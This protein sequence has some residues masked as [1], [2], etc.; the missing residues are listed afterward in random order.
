M[1]IIEVLLILTGEFSLIHLKVLGSMLYIIVFGIFTSKYA[2][3]Y[4]DKNGKYFGMFGICIATFEFIVFTL[5]LWEVIQIESMPIRKL[6]VSLLVVCVA[7]YHT[8][9]ILLIKLKNAISTKFSIA[10]QIL[11]GITYTLF[12]ILIIAE[13]SNDFYIRLL[14][15]FSILTLFTTIATFITNKI[16]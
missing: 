3:L 9:Y 14:L 11:I 13:I 5:Q 10:T 7:I 2:D 15:V 12:I 16:K 1:C 8:A 6:L 4:E